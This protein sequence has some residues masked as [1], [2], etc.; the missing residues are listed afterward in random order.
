MNKTLLE[1]AK[2]ISKA[3][4]GSSSGAAFAVKCTDK[5]LMDTLD[6]CLAAESDKPTREELAAC[7]GRLLAPYG[8]DEIDDRPVLSKARALL[9]R[10]EG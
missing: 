2:A 5:G 6:A 3:W 1:A 7:I 8:E 4:A 10:M 9:A